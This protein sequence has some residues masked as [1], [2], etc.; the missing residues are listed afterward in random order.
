MNSPIFMR[1]PFLPVYDFNDIPT[2][3]ELASERPTL[4]APFPFPLGPLGPLGPLKPCVP[5]TPQDALENLLKGCFK[6]KQDQAE[7][8]A[9]PGSF[10]DV[11]YDIYNRGFLLANRYEVSERDYQDAINIGMTYEEIIARCKAFELGEIA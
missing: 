2:D 1:D 6:S 11:Q 4:P 3:E 5:V 8:L 10:R 7:K 9:P